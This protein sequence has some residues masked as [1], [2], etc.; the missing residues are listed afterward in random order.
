MSHQ[1]DVVGAVGSHLQSNP[2]TYEGDPLPIIAPNAGG[3]SALDASGKPYISFQ[4]A[5]GTERLRNTN[6]QIAERNPTVRVT[7]HGPIDVGPIVPAELLDSLTDLFSFKSVFY[8]N[9]ELRFRDVFIPSEGR[10][11]GTHYITELEVSSSYLYDPR[12]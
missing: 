6:R 10:R 7:L 9:I 1:A 11:V 3:S 8:N 5:F 12:A 4:I 2:I